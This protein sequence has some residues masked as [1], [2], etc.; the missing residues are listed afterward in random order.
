MKVIKATN[1]AEF[2][3]DD[4][5]YERVV[6]HKWGVYGKNYLQDT[7]NKKILLHRFITNCPNGLEVDHKDHNPLNNQ[8]SNLRVCT[9]SQNHMNS[10]LQKGTTSK[11]KGVSWKKS[12]KRWYAYIKINCKTIHLGCFVSEE[13]A[14]RAYNDAASQ[15]FGDFVL[16]NDIET[17]YSWGS[18]KKYENNR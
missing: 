7:L 11:Y 15:Y 5:D 4:D 17:G 9:R 14:A 6:Q 12:A 13:E 10:N 1:G 2:L 8:K 16:L 18:L 3:V